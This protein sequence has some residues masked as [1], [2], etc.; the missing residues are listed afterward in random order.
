[1]RPKGRALSNCAGAVAGPGAIGGIGERFRVQPRAHP[2]E[3]GSSNQQA[4]S[5]RLRIIW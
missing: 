4:A 3:E 2:F 1:M 5:Q